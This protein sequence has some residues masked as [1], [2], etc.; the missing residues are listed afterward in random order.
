MVPGPII[1]DMAVKHFPAVRQA[2]LSNPGWGR[3]EMPLPRDGVGVFDAMQRMDE[4]PVQADYEAHEI[5]TI[6]AYVA[7]ADII[8]K[9]ISVGCD[10]GSIGI[11]KAIPRVFQKIT[12]EYRDRIGTDRC[13]IRKM[14]T[15]LTAKMSAPE[16]LASEKVGA[17]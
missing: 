11:G 8:G 17:A 4:M 7:A 13:P 5:A 2:L 6:I 10:L 16:Y 3:W 12:L 1:I 15:D 14:A 9:M